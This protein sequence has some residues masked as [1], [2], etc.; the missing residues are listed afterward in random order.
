MK[1]TEH[2]KNVFV[3]KVFGIPFFKVSPGIIALSFE[4]QFAFSLSFCE[5][6]SKINGKVLNAE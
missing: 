5:V 2:R 1:I 4:N 3:A 6:F